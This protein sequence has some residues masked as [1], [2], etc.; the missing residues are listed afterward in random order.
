VPFLLQPVV[1]VGLSTL[2]L[3]ARLTL[4]FAV[5]SALVA[6]GMLVASLKTR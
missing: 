3:G 5:G 2:F 4:G 6:A 1:G